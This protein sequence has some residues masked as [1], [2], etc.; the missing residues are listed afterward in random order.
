MN[1]ICCVYD[2]VADRYLDPFTGPTVE[3]CVR[4]FRRAT[5]K[6]GSQFNLYPEDY[7]LFHIGNFDPDTGV[8]HAE[9]PRSLGV[10]AKYKD[11]DP[12]LP[13]SLETPEV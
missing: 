9:T 1:A 6:P 5:N 8:I 12:Q 7:C 13:L 4:E 10:A 2:S 11:P 3:F